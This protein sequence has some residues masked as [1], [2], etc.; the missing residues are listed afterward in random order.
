MPSWTAF[1]AAELPAGWLEAVAAGD[2]ATVLALRDDSR[3]AGVRAPARPGRVGRP[4]L[5]PRARRARPRPVRGDAALAFLDDREVPRVPRG[6]GL[7]LAAP[8]ILQWSSEETKRR[9]LPPLASGEERWCQLFSEPGAGSDL[10]SLATSAVRDGDEWIVN[11]QKV[12][13]TYGHESEFAMLLARTDPTVPKNQGITYFGVDMRSPGVEVRALV[14]IAGEREFNEVFL[15]DVRVPDLHRISPVGE[16]WGATLTTLGAERHALSGTRKKRR[17]SDEILGGATFDQVL[18][19][20]RAGGHTADPVWRQR[21]AAEWSKGRVLALTTRRARANAAAGRAPGPEGSITKIAK[22]ASNQTLQVLAMDLLGAAA[23]SWDARAG[24]RHARGGQRRRRR[25]RPGRRRA[26]VPAH[27]GQLDRGRHVGDPAQHRRRA[28]PRPPPGARPVPRRGLVER[29]PVL[30]DPRSPRHHQAPSTRRPDGIV[31]VAGVKFLFCA[32]PAFG[33]V[34]PLLPLASAARDAGHEV[35]VA[36]TDPFLALVAR[37][38]FETHDV[39]IAI[40]AARAELLDSL[41]LSSM[42]RPTVGGPDVWLGGRMFLELVAP[43]TA[44][45][46]APVLAATRPDVVVYE[47]YDVGAAVAA[48]VAGI[49][50]ACHAVSPRLPDEVRGQLADLVDQLWSAHGVEAAAVRRVRRRR[51]RRQLPRRAATPRQSRRPRPAGAAAGSVPA[52][53]PRPRPVAGAAFATA[54]LPDARHGRRQRRRAAARRRGPR[55]PRCR[56]AGGPRFGHG[57]RARPAAP[58]RARGAVRR[59]GRGAARRRPRRPPRGQRHSA[60]RTR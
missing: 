23:T 51:V 27:A 46:L 17:A 10:A 30:I 15:T 41:G 35:A 18:A 43:R 29:A 12:W 20:A 50:A 7:P 56:R 6:S 54:R 22:A 8:T 14:N 21:L 45:D 19:L 11:G 26:P 32:R 52:S 4:G 44:A 38:G 5:G 47:S 9:L 25:D 57:R 48:A 16:G 34:Y 36:T 58:T 49:P 53:R 60:R 13:T 42:P 39:G 2:E 31:T 3:Q 28:G 37:L 40:E 24:R 59:P 1:L 55:Q 33:H